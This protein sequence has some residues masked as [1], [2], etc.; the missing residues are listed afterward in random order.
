MSKN[1]D[2]MRRIKKDLKKNATDVMFMNDCLDDYQ[3]NGE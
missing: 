3:E 2:D 1:I